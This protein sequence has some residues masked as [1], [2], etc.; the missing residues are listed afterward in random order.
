MT[1][2]GRDLRLDVFRGLA[3]VMIYI[4]HVPGT[5]YEHLTSRNFGFSDAA[6]GFVIMSGIAAGLA[7]S[8]AAPSGRPHYQ[9]RRALARAWTLYSTHIVTTMMAIAISAAAALWFGVGE[10]VMRN[11]LAAYHVRP[12]AFMIGIPTLSHQLGYFNILPL[13]TVLIA[14]TPAMIW[15]GRR[16]PAVLFALSLGI[17]A[18]A[19]QF[20]LNFPAYPNSG[21]WFFNP[22]SWQFIFVVGLL[23]GV[24]LRRGERFVP[25]NRGLIVAAIG[26]LLLVLLWRLVPPVA[27]VGGDV[28]SA[29]YRAGAPFYVV[30]YDK[31]FLVV[32]RMLHALAL[33]YVISALPWFR[34]MAAAD[35]SRSLVLLGRH[36]LPVFA[37]GSVLSILAQ[38][39]KAG[40]GGGFAIDTMLIFSGLAVQLGVAVV[41]EYLSRPTA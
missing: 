32:P 26:F 25:V 15:L 29:A 12:L 27:K 9:T 40:T 38:A 8:G 2:G 23:T 31:T 28:L 30:G 24:A 36:G 41:A 1:P 5:V 16:R 20:R 11:N 6:E 33:M 22:L 19:G 10:M 13:Y 14:L 7:Y 34:M 4:N 17:W 3:L 21:G 35:W 37:T 39:I 18:A